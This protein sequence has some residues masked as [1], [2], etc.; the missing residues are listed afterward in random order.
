VLAPGDGGRI[1]AYLEVQNAAGTGAGIADDV[2]P[3]MLLSEK[4]QLKF[5]LD[6]DG[7]VDVAYAVLS[8]GKKASIEKLRALNSQF[9]KFYEDLTKADTAGFAPIATHL[10]TENLMRALGCEISTG[11]CVDA[12]VLTV[13]VIDSGGNNRVK[14]NLLTMAVSGDNVS[15][16]GGAIVEY[17][18]YD[19]NGSI[20]RS[21]ICRSYERYRKPKEINSGSNAKVVCEME[22]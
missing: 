1:A 16:S 2:D 19:M 8:K 10:Q 21:N 15:H 12:K 22:N 13:R 18:M 3:Y 11:K 20:V 5:L 4:Q 6:D 17:K 7:Q 14:K 9:D